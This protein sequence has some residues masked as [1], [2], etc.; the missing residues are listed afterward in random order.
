MTSKSLLLKPRMS[1]KSYAAAESQ[2]TYV[3]EIPAK[4]SSEQVAQAVSAQYG[5]TVLKVKTAKTAGKSR[6]SFRRS[7]R[8]VYRGQSAAVRKAYVRLK[9]GDK[10]PIFAAVEKEES[11]KTTEN[12]PE[13]VKTKKTDTV[14]DTVTKTVDD[15]KRSEQK[16]SNPLRQFWRNK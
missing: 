12:E 9:E 15:K 4:V 14:K 11:S 7:G 6:R 10:L 1:E 3:F 2:Q 16:K 13:K 8:S 5:V